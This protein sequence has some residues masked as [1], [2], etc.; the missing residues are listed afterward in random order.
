MSIKIFNG[1]LLAKGTDIFEF[2]EKF[3]TLV[4]RE[5]KKDTSR[6]IISDA[7]QTLDNI[8]MGQRKRM[9]VIKKSQKVSTWNIPVE[10]KLDAILMYNS[11]ERFTR[12]KGSKGE[13]YAEVILVKN[14]EKDQHAFFF[15]GEDTVSSQLENIPGVIYYP[16]WNNSDRPKN[17]SKK[18][19]KHRL[20]F[21]EGVGDL[22]GS[23]KN[24]GYSYEPFST[25]PEDTSV[26][27]KGLKNYL[28]SDEAVI[29][30]YEK[31]VETVLNNLSFE[32]AIKELAPRIKE[33]KQVTYE[34]FSVASKIRSAEGF[35]ENNEKV[36]KS[37]LI[38]ITKDILL[39]VLTK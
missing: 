27:F 1:Y 4:S 28:D 16:Y 14:A 22:W 38:P 24:L 29:P 10:K 15:F 3:K 12:D 21:W 31:R 2:H 23:T 39:S 19:W 7:I 20:E 8:T 33:D 18:E 36:I 32:L 9:N 11:M 26:S 5:H 6:S 17:V 35:R 37:K 25:L 34:I 13:T 30:S